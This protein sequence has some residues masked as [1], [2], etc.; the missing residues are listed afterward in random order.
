MCALL[1]RIHA[2]VPH[3]LL[4]GRPDR[5]A[6]S[7]ARILYPYA[8]LFKLDN[9]IAYFGCGP[10]MYSVNAFG[11][12]APDFILDIDVFAI[13]GA[14]VRGLFEYAYTAA[15]L[16]L[17]PHLPDDIQLLQQNFPVRWGNLQIFLRVI[18]DNG[19]TIGAVSLNGAPC[20]ACIVGAGHQV[21]LTWETLYALHNN[22]ITVAITYGPGSAPSTIPK[23]AHF[24]DPALLWMQQQLKHAH[25][26]VVDVNDNCSAPAD[27]A[28]LQQ[29]VVQFV[30]KLNADGLGER[31]ERY[32]ASAFLE[33][34]A[35]AVARCRG[36]L[37]GSIAPLP[38]QPDSW[39]QYG[40][41]TSQ[42]AGDASFMASAS[43]IGVGL[44]NKLAFDASSHDPTDQQIAQI[45]AT[46]S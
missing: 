41:H 23:Q 9:P 12:Q 33:A 45:W 21:E 39:L 27:Q 10:G 40:M 11:K 31:Y 6:N 22:T 17:S 35:S 4:A 38:P 32:H 46:C 8:A 5:A 42:A 29:R 2:F 19:A 14:M 28:A 16:V 37:D 24:D 34:L 20:P 7:M 18:R 25:S 36:R 43:N 30:A 3:R 13:P 1:P 44:V 26:S 15:T